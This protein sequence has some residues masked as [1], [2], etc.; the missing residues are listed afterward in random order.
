MNLRRH[1]SDHINRLVG[2]DLTMAFDQDL[3][4]MRK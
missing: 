4:E 3:D 1:N 2:V